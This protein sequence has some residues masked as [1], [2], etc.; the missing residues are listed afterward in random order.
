[1]SEDAT[2]RQLQQAYDMIKANRKA[3][4]QAVLMPILKADEDNANA[5][6]LLAN[7]LTDPAEIREALENV[8]RLRPGD[9]KAQQMLDNL[10]ARSP[11]DE[12]PLSDTGFGG[13]STLQEKP[14]RGQPVVVKSGGGTNPLL[15]ILAIVGGLV[16]LGCAA[17]FILPTIGISL[18][19]QQIVE[20]AMTQVPELQEIFETIT[21][22]PGGGFSLPTGNVVQRGTIEYGQRVQQ[23]V[24]TFDD[25]AWTFTG[26]A[27]DRVTIE[28]N[29]TDNTLDPQVYLFSSSNQ[30]LGYDDDGGS[31]GNN[32]R[33]V[34]TLPA[35]GTYTIR[36][37]AFSEG[38]DYELI[39]RRN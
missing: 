32:S 37:S 21:A 33:L 17:C 12:F 16:V 2:R 5:W 38:G 6:W 26:G 9:S 22:I 3:D 34:V 35:N 28:V 27:G 25:D 39:L 29:A 15:I 11:A 24:D 23:T 8:L 14:K 20:Q 19:G 31:T 13:M 7:A 1:M 36:V 30:Q 18:F 4:A 10:N